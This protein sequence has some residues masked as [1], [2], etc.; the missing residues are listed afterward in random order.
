MGT[1][2]GFVSGLMIATSLAGCSGKPAAT[3]DFSAFADDKTDTFSSRMKVLRALENGSSQSADYTGSPRYL[4]YTLSGHTGDIVDIWV[5]SADGDAIA[6]LTNSRFKIVAK[7][8]D[9][10]DSTRDSHLVQTLSASGTYYV[11]F[12]EYDGNQASFDI[13]LGGQK[14]VGDVCEEQGLNCGSVDDGSGNRV[15]CGKCKSPETCGGGGKENVCGVAAAPE[16]NDPF[17]PGSC[18]GPA[19]TVQEAASK[20]PRGATSV[21]LSG[22]LRF[23]IL[24]RSCTNQTGCGDYTQ[25]FGSYTPQDKGPWTATDPA[26]LHLIN[27]FGADGVFLE[28]PSTASYPNSDHFACADYNP[29]RL[30]VYVGS[31]TIRSS[32]YCFADGNRDHVSLDNARAL[33]TNHCARI[34]ASGRVGSAQLYTEYI[35]AGLVRY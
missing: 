33:A 17:D 13:S 2:L 26:A 16:S 30:I 22:K 3:D 11:I 5:R 19:M 23:E 21:T 27:R 29:H 6:W 35:M 7:N 31:P 28:I 14:P 12:R 24:Q 15:N 9:A 1:Y 25:F 20:F 10:E 32:F 8:D 34:E 4:A 18:V